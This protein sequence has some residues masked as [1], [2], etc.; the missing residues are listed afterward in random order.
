[1][2]VKLRLD[3]RLVE[4]GLTTSRER[5]RALIMSGAVTVNGQIADKPGF[6][7][8]PTDSI[9]V[10]H[11]A[12]QY[13]S[14]G[15]LK[16]ERAIRT[17]SP[18]IGGKICADIG[19]STGGFTDCML[20]NGAR[21]VY[22]VDTGYGQLAVS[23]RNDERV[24]CLERTNA[25]YITAEQIPEPIDFFSV[26]VAFISLSLIVPALVPLLSEKAE[27]VLL[28]K[29]Q[30]EAGR[31]LV[32]KNGVVRD[33]KVHRSVVIST[34]DMLEKLS[35]MP[36]GLT[37]SPIKGPKGNIEFL[38]Y[39]CKDRDRNVSISD[40]DDVIQRAHCELAVEVVQ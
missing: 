1:M 30:F 27:G 14:R 31:E 26:D 7:L 16:L 20:Q 17:F 23:L 9:Y 22:A 18:S 4:L 36:V 6:T 13:V 21:R 37:F 38:V 5:A 3:T 34:L 39:V 10:K 29:P 40:I 24:I 28:I 25:R 15:G 19:A 8:A 35:V 12:I 11:P 33:A 32:G 2:A